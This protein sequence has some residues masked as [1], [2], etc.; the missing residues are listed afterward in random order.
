MKKLIPL[1]SIS[2]LSAQE[3]CCCPQYLPQSQ[4]T[5]DCGWDVTISASALIW[6]PQCE[7]LDYVILN[8]AGT[9]FANSDAKVKRVDFDWDYGVRIGLGYQLPCFMMDLGLIYTYYDAK[10]SDS[11]TAP[12]LGGLYQI[13][14][15]PGSD[16]TPATNAN[17][18]WK[19]NL[20]MLDFQMSTTF[21][22]RCFLELT[23]F[24][25]LS[26]AWIDQKFNIQTRGGS[27]TQITNAIV[28]DDTIR[29][30]NDFWGIGPKAGLNT[31]WKFGCGFSIFGDMNASLLFGRFD[32]DQSES[33]LL[34]GVNPAFIYLDL[35]DNRFW[36]SRF[37]LDLNLGLQWDWMF[38]CDNYH[39]SL[40]AGWEHLY[41]PGQNQL[42]RFQTVTSPGINLSTKGDLTFQGVTLKGSLTF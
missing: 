23:P 20:N 42:L 41:L 12:P 32:L 14:T 8:N 5:I 3:P 31:L 33:V 37:A 10:A 19:L 39:L 9:A 22:P 13:W 16:L 35:D 6:R 15:I 17:A 25:A 21:V 4:Y 34:A 40:Q 7:G 28:L 30:K 27:S 36:L 18:K 11:S 1:L 26:T 38:C 29:M 24:I 2:L